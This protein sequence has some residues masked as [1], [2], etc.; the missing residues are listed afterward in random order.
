VFSL[1]ASWLSRTRVQELLKWT[2]IQR[3]FLDV[4]WD[5]ET[6]LEAVGILHELINGSIR[7]E[8]VRRLEDTPSPIK[9]RLVKNIFVQEIVD[10]SETLNQ[11]PEANCNT[12][13]VLWTL[14]ML[15]MAFIFHNL[16]DRPP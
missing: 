9:K 16:T 4:H 1:V 3:R 6:A 14:R 11:Y 13:N 7:D 8:L 15:P 10:W 2:V 12:H 5:R